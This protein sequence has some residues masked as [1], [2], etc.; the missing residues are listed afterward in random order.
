MSSWHDAYLSIA[1]TFIFPLL[2]GCIVCEQEAEMSSAWQMLKN[3]CSSG[4]S[5]R[6]GHFI[7]FVEQNKILLHNVLLLYVAELTTCLLAC[8]LH[9]HR[10]G[11]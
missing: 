8:S 7:L 5:H 6:L 2:L 1:I 11:D 3:I 9:W 4:V 10:T